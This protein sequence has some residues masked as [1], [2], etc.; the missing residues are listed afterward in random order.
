MYGLDQPTIYLYL[1]DFDSRLEAYTLFDFLQ[2]ILH[3]LIQMDNV[4][5]QWGIW[6]KQGGS[7]HEGL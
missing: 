7:V 2:L 5:H 6:T 3:V 1:A 4:S